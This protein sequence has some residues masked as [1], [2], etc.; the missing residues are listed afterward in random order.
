LAI[1]FTGS[2]EEAKAFL[3]TIRVQLS[4]LRTRAVARGLVVRHFKMH[5]ISF[6]FDQITNETVIVLAKTAPRAAI[7]DAVDAAFAGD[8]ARPMD[9]HTTKE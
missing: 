3:Q 5:A 9:M 4:K 2:I 7:E 1:T 8:A 6:A